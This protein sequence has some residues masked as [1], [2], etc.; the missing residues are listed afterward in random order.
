MFAPFKNVAG[1][2]YGYCR[3]STVGQVEHGNSLETQKR[4]IEQWCATKNYELVAVEVDDGVSGTLHFT[5]RPALMRLVKML[6]K[7]NILLT[8]TTS[9]LSR[10]FT[11][12]VNLV[13]LIKQKGAIFASIDENV[14]TDS[15]YGETMF[16][17]MA[18]ISNLQVKQISEQVIENAETFRQQGRH[19]G[20]PGYGYKL[21]D[22]TKK[23]SGLI[24]DP[25]QQVVIKL[26]KTLR[27][28]QDMTFPKICDTLNAQKIPSPTGKEWNTRTITRIYEQKEVA[29]KGRPSYGTT[30]SAESNY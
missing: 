6:K 7:D 26:I 15:T 21:K 22:K 24:E 18:V 20:R 27:D 13:E 3:V 17:M 5:E 19:N 1:Y 12:V 4:R 11:D 14:L 10:N 28:E 16:R 8:I 2:V 25:E 23:G 30:T 29:T 9:R